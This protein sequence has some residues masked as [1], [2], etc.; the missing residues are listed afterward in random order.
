ME[1]LFQSAAALQERLRRAGI[2]SA[3]I[4]GVAVGVWG[5]PR[6]TRDVDIKVLLGRDDA[7]RLLDVLGSDFQPLLPDDPLQCLSHT[8]I[9]FVQDAQGTRLDLLLADVI[10]DEGAILRAREMVL[11][12]GAIAM[13]C[14]PEDLIVYKLISTRKRDYQDVEGVIR[15]QGDK[16]DDEYVLSWLREFEQALDDSTLVMTYSHMREEWSKRYPEA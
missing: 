8:G 2:A 7:Q 11:Q 3:L 4:G 1:N 9:L 13:V 15:R 5:E 12:S 16:L 10:Y 6:L 14:S